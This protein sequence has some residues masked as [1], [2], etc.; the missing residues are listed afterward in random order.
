MRHLLD[1]RSLSQAELEKLLVSAQLMAA[2]WPAN[3]LQDSS[4]DKL[5]I[6][7]FYE[8]STRSRISFEVAAKRLGMQVVNFTAAGS[9]VEKGESL[10]DSFQ[11]L[12]A[13]AP[14][15]VV[16]RL[17]EPDA[18]AL[19]AQQVAENL[20]IVNAGDG[21]RSHPSQALLD[22]YTI[23]Q[24]KG[25]IEGLNIVI[26]GDIVHSRVAASNIDVLGRLGAAEIRL[27]GPA[28]FLPEEPVSERVVVYHR[29]DEAV[30]G[31]DVIMMLR[32]QRERIGETDS[33]D[34][35]DYHRDWCLNTERLG[36]AMHDCVVMHPGPVN[37]GVEITAAVA[38][39]P[40]S[41]ILQQVANGVHVRMAI[42]SAL[43][44]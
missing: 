16:I 25:S 14:D 44:Q 19:L 12:Q 28:A 27:C 1:T 29:L 43:L 42:I 38:D 36:L 23:R 40:R 13:M 21:S 11:A 18:L 4:R 30:V 37:R 32:I 22:A 41:L 5:L 39:G 6:N 8:P 10:Y 20:H 31:A 9:S 35:G 15:V 26:A 7:M 17:D 2:D 3:I 34:P 24:S 33:P